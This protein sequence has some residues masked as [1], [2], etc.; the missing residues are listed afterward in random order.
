MVFHGLHRI[1]VIDLNLIA[2]G[3]LVPQNAKIRTERA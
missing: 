1:S 3:R 2:G